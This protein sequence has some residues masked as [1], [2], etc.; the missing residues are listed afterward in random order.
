MCH[1][2]AGDYT[3]ISQLIGRNETQRYVPRALSPRTRLAS[4]DAT[5]L[6]C[7]ADRTHAAHSA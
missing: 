1:G 3:A 4:Q 7:A 6:I 5:F 2:A